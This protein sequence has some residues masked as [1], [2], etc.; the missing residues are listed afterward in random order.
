MRVTIDASQEE[1]DAKREQLLK[2]LAGDSA[3]IV[4]KAVSGEKPAL[5]PRRAAITAQNQMMDHW[6][7]R[8]Q[9]MIEAIKGEI[10]AVLHQ[11]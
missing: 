1:F 2:T 3:E 4:M 5:T 9:A 10:S 6:D 11:G 8:Y 7:V